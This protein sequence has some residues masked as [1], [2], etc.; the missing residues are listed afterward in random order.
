LFQS[1]LTRELKLELYSIQG[2][3]EYWIFDRERQKVKVYRRE[4]AVL[5]LAVTLYQGDNVTSPLLPGFNSPI[6][7]LLG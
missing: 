5:K 4:N 3:L 1:S 2:V 7:R 6:E